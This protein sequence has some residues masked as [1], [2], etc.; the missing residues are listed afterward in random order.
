MAAI[1]P[2]PTY[3]EGPGLL[4]SLRRHLPMAVAIVAGFTV[5]GIAFGFVSS[6]SYIATSQVVIVEK[7]HTAG[8]PVDAF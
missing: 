8:A 4:Q 1:T 7:P 3:L 5:L 2:D 6:K